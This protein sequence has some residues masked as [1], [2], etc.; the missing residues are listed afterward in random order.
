MDEEIPL[1]PLRSATT[2]TDSKMYD[3][4]DTPVHLS[5]DP[6]RLHKVLE[7]EHDRD[8]LVDPTH[9][10]TELPDSPRL[11]KRSDTMASSELSDETATDSADE[12]DWD[13]EEDTMSA[14][15]ETGGRRAEDEVKARRG[16]V[17]WR[18]FMKLS[19]T[20]RTLIVGALG[21]GLLITPLIIVGVRF[22]SSP[23]W[24]H[25]RT[26]SLWL[27]ISWS[28]GV[29]TYLLIDSVPH[30]VLALLKLLGYKVERLKTPIEVSSS[31]HVLECTRADWARVRV[32]RSWSRRC[33]DG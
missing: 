33:L 15:R 11:Q 10:P 1:P 2:D 27:T 28:A 16:K 20:V 17:V 21:A 8:D 14:H 26:W 23:A 19:R 22:R 24:E 18:L 12:F 7:H 32:L 30:F 29:G 9:H 4:V 13:A 25:V 5:P 3:Y 6:E 31:L